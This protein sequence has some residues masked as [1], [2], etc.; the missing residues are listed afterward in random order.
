MTTT[1][2]P[3]GALQSPS[4][5]IIRTPR[6][7]NKCASTAFL[8]ANVY[9]RTYLSTTLHFLTYYY[10]TKIRTELLAASHHLH[11]LRS[12]LLGIVI[13]FRRIFAAARLAADR[14]NR[15][16]IVG[17]YLHS[18]FVSHFW[19]TLRGPFSAVSKPILQA[20]R[21]LVRKLSTRSTRSIHAFAPLEFN[22]KTMK[23]ASGKRPFAP[24][25]SQN[26]KEKRVRILLFFLTFPF[27]TSFEQI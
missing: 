6:R 25:R 12:L 1:K 14:T 10:R 21:T 17:A 27:F 23:S 3:W 4:L 11:L 7:G 16:A 13:L 18:N 8:Q 9:Y 19:Q 26:F 20:N 5:Q 24:L 15:D 2:S 22:R